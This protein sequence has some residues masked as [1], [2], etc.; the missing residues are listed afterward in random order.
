[1]TRSFEAPEGSVCAICRCTHWTHLV[2]CPSFSCTSCGK[3]GVSPD[4]ANGCPESELL[5]GVPNM[6]VQPHVM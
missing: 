2:S 5:W 3:R 1:M 6:Q 4:H